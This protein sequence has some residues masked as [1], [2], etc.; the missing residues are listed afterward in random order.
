LN[1]W[2]SENETGSTG[3]VAF[4]DRNHSNGGKWNIPLSPHDAMGHRE[5]GEAARISHQE[6]QSNTP[7]YRK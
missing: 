6:T 1:A 7:E 5:R 2:K 3:A 4:R